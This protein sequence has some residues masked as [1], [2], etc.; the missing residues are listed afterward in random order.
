M[1]GGEHQHSLCGEVQAPEQLHQLRGPGSPES[2]ALDDVHSALASPSIQGALPG[3]LPHLPR[4]LG[5]IIPR[6]RAEHDAAAPP[7]RSANR[8]LPSASSTLLLPGFLVAA[9]DKA[10]ALRHVG[11]LTLIV[12]VHLDRLV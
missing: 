3:E 1:I 11:A 2:E 8:A 9:G 5:A 12:Q 10:T 4:D 7:V 6:S